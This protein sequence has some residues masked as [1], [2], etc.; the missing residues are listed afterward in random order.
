M[1]YND[2][3]LRLRNLL[4]LCERTYSE[5]IIKKSRDEADEIALLLPQLKKENEVEEI[6]KSDKFQKKI[7]EV[8]NARITTVVN[9]DKV[10]IRIYDLGEEFQAPDS[11][12]ELLCAR[13]LSIHNSTGN[14]NATHSVSA[15][16]K[17][18]FSSKTNSMIDI[19]LD[20][21]LF[22]QTHKK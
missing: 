6:I 3:I 17:K 20:I 10:T 11:L 18:H 2:A 4:E 12:K 1:K 8:L 22:L 14:N 15:Y 13:S 19:E 7:S 9:G 5:S 16:R 21:N